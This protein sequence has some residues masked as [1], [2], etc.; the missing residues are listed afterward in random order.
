MAHDARDIANEIIRRGE[1]QGW[2][3]THLQV[4]KLVYYCHAWMLGVHGRPLA[5]QEVTAWRYGR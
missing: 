1:D 3:F 4:Q 5:T 2:L